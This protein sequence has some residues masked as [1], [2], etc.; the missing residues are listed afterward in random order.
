MT[1]IAAGNLLGDEVEG[2]PAEWIAAKYPQG[3]RE[4]RAGRTSLETY[5]ERLLAAG[6]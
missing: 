2:W 3:V 1:G 5:A 4:I 6:A